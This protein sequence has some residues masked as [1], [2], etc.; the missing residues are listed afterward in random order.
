MA[1]KVRL[2]RKGAKKSPFYRIVVTDVRSP[3]D[4]R[5]IESIG[6]YDPKTDPAQVRIDLGRLD[7]WLGNGAKASRTVTA[8][9]KRAREE[10]SAAT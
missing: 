8:L 3:R 2:S 1:V 9:A 4:G 10:A 6:H 5:F 7:Y